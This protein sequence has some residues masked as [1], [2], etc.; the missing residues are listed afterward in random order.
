MNVAAS[1]ASSDGE[2]G[3]PEWRCL[4]ISRNHRVPA[5]LSLSDS[6]STCSDEN[7][8]KLEQQFKQ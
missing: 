8:K 7:K 3:V 5:I 6:A 2:A 4:R 1:R